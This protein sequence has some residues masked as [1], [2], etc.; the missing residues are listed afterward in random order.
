MAQ[1]SKL[2]TKDKGF[3]KFG[4][5]ADKYKILYFIKIIGDIAVAFRVA[6]SRNNC[7]AFAVSDTA[8]AR[9][10]GVTHGGPVDSFI[11]SFPQRTSKVSFGQAYA[12]ASK[13]QTH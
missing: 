8:L 7:D 6:L 12:P 11:L 2:K 9:S 5:N 10:R 4:F 13:V 3:G 1:N